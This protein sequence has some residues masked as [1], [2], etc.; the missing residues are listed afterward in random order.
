[1]GSL[2]GKPLHNICSPDLHRDRGTFCGVGDG[3]GSVERRFTAIHF[4]DAVA[5]FWFVVFPP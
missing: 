5:D 1:M 3:H 4:G 2:G